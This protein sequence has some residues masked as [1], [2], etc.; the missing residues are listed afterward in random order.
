[1]LPKIK[2]SKFEGGPYFFS[3]LRS[4]LRASLSSGAGVLGCAS[5][6]ASSGRT[7]VAAALISST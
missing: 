7:T 5:L 4:F 1:M 3:A 2:L 6:R